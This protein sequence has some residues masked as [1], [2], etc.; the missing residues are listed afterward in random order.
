[1]ACVLPE[2]SDLLAGIA[3]GAVSVALGMGAST[4]AINEGR[5]R[6]A[7]DLVWGAGTTTHVLLPCGSGWVL[8]EVAAVGSFLAIVAW[9]WPRPELAQT[10]AQPPAPG[11]SRRM[12]VQP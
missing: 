3:D 7:A 12:E 10:R 4:L 9:L 2:S 8:L 11:V 6:G 1:M 5:L